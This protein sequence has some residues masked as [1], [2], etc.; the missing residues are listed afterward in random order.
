MPQSKQHPSEEGGPSANG[1][2]RAD[3]AAATAFALLGSYVL[4]ESSAMQWLGAIT[5]KFVGAGLI[6]LSLLLAAGAMASL[7]RARPDAVKVS[8][9][10]SQIWFVAIF[11]AWIAALPYLGFIA[12]SVLGFTAIAIA[13]P[14]LDERSP[15]SMAKQGLGAIAATMVAWAVLSQGL[16][17]PLPVGSL[18]R[19]LGA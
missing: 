15:A 11:A 12:S 1:A 14:R 4:W 9:N 3:I 5:P 17:I 6:A 2:P 19:S 10:A 16:N 8:L 7:A 13:T 18:V